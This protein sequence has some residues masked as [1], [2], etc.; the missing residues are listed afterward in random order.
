[1]GDRLV[2]RQLL[3]KGHAFSVFRDE[4]VQPS[5]R[6]AAREIVERANAIAVVAL[7]GDGNILLER[8]WRQATGKALLE[9]PAGG[10]EPGEEPVGAVSRE[11]QEET[12]YLPRNIEPLGGFYLAPGYSSEYLHVFLAT[13][14]VPSQLTAEDTEEIELVPTPPCDIPRLI[15]DGSLED[16]KSIAGLLLYLSS[17]NA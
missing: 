16:G 5:G 12:G 10:I 15:A 11:M 4:V 2:S 6:K 9:I 14:L 7:D 1:V 8:Q 17:Q 3:F 13:D